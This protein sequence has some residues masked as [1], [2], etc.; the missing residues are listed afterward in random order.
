MGSDGPMAL[1]KDAYA[2]LLDASWQNFR[3]QL[4]DAFPEY[5]LPASP[6]LLAGSEPGSPAKEFDPGKV[7]F[8]LE[9]SDS[10]PMTEQKSDKSDKSEQSEQSQ[11]SVTDN[12]HN[13]AHLIQSGLDGLG[14]QE[15]RA[16]RHRLRLRL[17]ALTA[18]SMVSGQCLHEAISALGLTK[19]SIQDMNEFLNQIADFISLTFEDAES[20]SDDDVESFATSINMLWLRDES[21]K[22][23]HRRK[24]VWAWPARESFGIRRSMTAHSVFPDPPPAPRATHNAAPAQ[25]IMDIFLAKEGEVHRRIFGPK[26]LNQFRSIKE[27]LLAGDTNRLVAELTFVRINDLASPPEK[28]HPLMYIEPL[29]AT[30][31]VGNGI[32]IG[33]QTDPAYANWGGWTYLE[34]GFAA[35]LLLEIGLRMHLLRCW[36]YW[37]GPEKWWNWFDLLLACTGLSDIYFGLFFE[38]TD[39][40][41]G[42]SLLRFCRL[43]RLVRIV[44]VFRIKM[45]KDLR[46]MVKGLVAGVKTLSLAFALLFAV[47]Y[48]IAGF[49]TISIGVDSR[50]QA[51]GLTSY[52]Q[53]IPATMFTSFRCFNGECVNDAGQPIP[54]LLAAEFGLPFILGYVGSYMLVTMGIFNVILGVYVDIT[55]RAA[56]EN[57]AQSAEAHSR[58]SIRIARTTRELLKRFA[59]AYHVFTEL[60]VDPT[61]PEDTKDSKFSKLPS[62]ALLTEDDLR[63][64][65]ITKELFLLVIQDGRVQKLMDELDLPPDR[66]NLFEI[67]D[68]DSSGTLQIAELLH[69]LLKIRGEINKSDTIASLLATKAVQSMLS[70]FKEESMT[71]MRSLNLGI[72]NRLEKL[73]EQGERMEEKLMEPARSFV[74]FAS[75]RSSISERAHSKAIVETTSSKGQP[76]APTR[77]LLTQLPLKDLQASAQ[78]N[79][80]EE[81]DTPCPGL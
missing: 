78:P 55:M 32:M 15:A 75:R 44:K 58:E 51:I 28:L 40:V 39:S 33:F 13:S 47:L 72:S 18:D 56:K 53:N 57:E 9:E 35:C 36:G 48:V 19:F 42:T 21:Q 8:T 61:S 31:I 67:I 68:A 54:S 29:V 17:N 4:L 70:E 81:P 41:A 10:L 34:I 43:I 45:L 76:P 79:V 20:E 50:T 22:H 80:H 73:E 66:A 77:K 12:A 27:I 74:S 26:H 46:L 16:V 11:S 69:G 60:E 59:A 24:P 49:A 71:M 2:S 37:C 63:D 23:H 25:A 14:P 64:V 38:A 6:S 1:D 30:L 52:F 65:A 62:S 5:G 3:Q 7:T